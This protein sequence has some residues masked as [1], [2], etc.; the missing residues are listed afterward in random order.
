M[1]NVLSQK[2]NNFSVYDP[3]RIEGRYLQTYKQRPVTR[4]DTDDTLRLGGG[5]VQ[6][7]VKVLQDMSN[8]QL[9]TKAPTG[10][11]IYLS[12]GN[13]PR[14]LPSAARLLE[15]GSNYGRGP[16]IFITGSPLG[17]KVTMF[18]SSDMT[19]DRQYQ[20]IRINNMKDFEFAM[21]S[22]H[23]RE[24]F[25]GKYAGYRG[26]AAVNPFLQRGSDFQSALADAGRF[27][28]HNI[29]KA[30]AQI[31]KMIMDEVLPLS[32][33]ILG[34]IT[35]ATGGLENLADRAATSL[36]T[37]SLTEKT[38]IS[39]NYDPNMAN[40]IQDPRLERYFK[41]IQAQNFQF[42]D[43]PSFEE[44]PQETH[45][46]MITKGRLLS[47]ENAEN[48]L[49]EQTGIVSNNMLEI[50][51]RFAN[52]QN[53]NLRQFKA[54]LRRSTN[55]AQKLNVIRYFQNR[56]K[57]DVLP[58]VENDP[59]LVHMLSHDVH[60]MVDIDPVSTKVLDLTDHPLLINGD[61]DHRS[62]NQSF[63]G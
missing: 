50:N 37:P 46:Q 38:Y 28:V 6:L 45:Q 54:G 51:K 53:D 13:P 43:A 63:H 20:P 16:A 18:S 47:K 12:E 21:E 30:Y 3:Q 61:F 39:G 57:Q 14:F 55:N 2:P 44:F 7:G 4:Q 19:E 11:K 27:V 15:K 56:L 31:P 52:S 26:Q 17:P 40:L 32:G 49:R 62:L 36:T 41:H 8:G 24:D 48:Y 59:E 10:E 5:E 9:F 22:G 35:G 60:G 25:S 23:S 42:P 58:K 33:T 34:G 29:F 1:G